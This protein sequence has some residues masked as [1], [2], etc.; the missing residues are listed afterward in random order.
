MA[1]SEGSVFLRKASGVVREM[2][3]RDGM[4][5]GYLSAT[6]I[7]GLVFFLF[8]GG[9]AF[10]NANYLLADVISLVFFL[11]IYVVYA[12]LA[13]AM[14]RSGGDYVFTSRLL[15][16]SIGF[17][18]A[19]AAWIF[20]GFYFVFQAASAVVEGVFAPMLST[21]GVSTGNDWW[22]H[23]GDTITHP[24]VRVPI[25]IALMLGAAWLMVSGMRHYVRLQK[26]FMM[27]A[28]IIGL[29]IITVLIVFVSKGTFFGHFDHFQ[30]Q[31]GGIP[32]DSVVGRAK[33]L[34]FHPEH[35]SLFDTLGFS[36]LLTSLFVWTIWSSELLGEIKSASKLKTSFNMFAGAGV[37]QFITFAIGIAGVYAWLG[38]DWMRS[39]SWL[40]VNH[41]EQLGGSWD[42]RGV[43][44]LFYIPTLNGVLGIIIFL[45]FLGPVSMSIFNPVL[46]SSRLMLAMS[47]DRV[48]P[49]FFGKVNSKG[50]PYVAI[51][52]NVALSIALAILIEFVPDLT[53][54]L[55]YSS[56]ATLF[57]ILGSIL[58]GFLFPKTGKS[59][60]EASP[61]A[62]FRVLGFPAVVVFG[63]I[64]GLFI[65]GSMA[66]MLAHPGF[67]LLEAGSARVGLITFVAVIVLALVAFPII[68]RSR[69]NQGI[70]ID[71]AFK[72]V[73][74]E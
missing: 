56:F 7:Y 51:G 59:I 49:D 33:S 53:K 63:A 27:P 28:A 29:I 34:G 20:W 50:A 58:G 70:E 71:Y 5:Y 19:W 44:T 66:I 72:N 69:R 22:V 60:F 13:S 12:N 46:S 74:P 45:C 67:G 57:G 54:M 21:I 35:S 1:S 30:K 52:F 23:A 9:A 14:P 17:M 18:I 38:A 4:Y 48:L 47:F 61:G 68:K 24:W 26:Y 6:G 41:P 42:F 16:P 37:L 73:P 65:G 32:S 31:V 8:V 62:N 64:G 11:A 2:S 3:S 43:E 10:P 39:F 15:S 36:V 55:F 40:V 25:E